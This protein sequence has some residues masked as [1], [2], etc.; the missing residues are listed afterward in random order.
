MFYGYDTPR[1]RDSNYTCSVLVEIGIKLSHSE[2]D[3][4]PGDREFS[5][6]LIDEPRIAVQ[7]TKLSI[8]K[9][10]CV[11]EQEWIWK[12]IDSGFWGGWYTK[13]RNGG[14]RCWC[15][16]SHDSFEF[17]SNLSGINF[18]QEMHGIGMKEYSVFERLTGP[19]ASSFIME[20]WNTLFLYIVLNN[21]WRVVAK[22]YAYNHE[23]CPGNAAKQMKI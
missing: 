3:G 8:C 6:S 10:V 21:I 9:R 17:T 19:F 15:S 11:L 7:L 18:R 23:C 14:K 5:W 1:I 20:S 16:H 13:C 22:E 4:D 2:L 12:I